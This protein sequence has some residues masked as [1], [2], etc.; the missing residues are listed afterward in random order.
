M[1]LSTALGGQFALSSSS[2]LARP[3]L[4]RGDITGQEVVMRFRS[5]AL[6]LSVVLLLALAGG[7]V[8]AQQDIL[9]PEE[10]ARVTYI[11]SAFDALN[12]LDTYTIRGEQSMLMDM[13]MMEGSVA[14][15]AQIA[16][17]WQIVPRPDGNIESAA[18]TV[19]ATMIMSFDVPG[20]ET[21]E[22]EMLLVAESIFLDM[23]QYFHLTIESDME[24]VNNAFPDMWFVINVEEYIAALQDAGGGF[25]DIDFELLSSMAGNE[26]ASKY[27]IP[28][29]PETVRSI[30]EEDVITIEG[31]TYRVFSMEIDPRGL[32]PDEFVGFVALAEQYAESGVASGAETDQDAVILANLSEIMDSLVVRQAVWINTT[33]GLP[34]RVVLDQ[35]YSALLTL[36]SQTDPEFELSGGEMRLT[37]DVKLVDINVPFTTKPPDNAFEIPPELLLE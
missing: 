7:A 15:D 4:P 14:F 37:S 1:S 33:S 34:H 29:N 17:T 5:L 35:D 20:S 6:A 28:V 30:T 21:E 12:G 36:I 3:T 19:E 26:Y 25:I 18:G 27:I 13:Q 9:S 10:Q 24:E 16:L 31:I 23:R 2:P 11:M 22:M 32:I 8:S